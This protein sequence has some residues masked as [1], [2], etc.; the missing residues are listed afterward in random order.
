MTQTGI[1]GWVQKDGKIVDGKLD[2]SRLGVKQQ[3]QFLRSQQLKIITHIN[4]IKL[5]AENRFKSMP[6]GSTMTPLQ[7][8]LALKLHALKSSCM[9]LQGFNDN[10]CSL[11]LSYEK[12]GC[13]AE[14]LAELQSEIE[15]RVMDL[16]H[17]ANEASEISLLEKAIEI[18]SVLR[19]NAHSQSE[20]PEPTPAFNFSHHIYALKAQEIL[21]RSY[22]D[23]VSEI[24]KTWPDELIVP[25]YYKLIWQAKMDTFE[26]RMKTFIHNA[27]EQIT[28]FR[29]IQKSGV[30]PSELMEIGGKVR[31]M[32]LTNYTQALNL[33]VSLVH[34]TR[35]IAVASRLAQVS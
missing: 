24:A 27:K 15:R 3:T 18:D 12:Y 14:E 1:S 20:N 30:N 33:G 13:T 32:V 34:C 7:K 26:G 31:R 28:F 2:V 5:D 23:L 10:L 16:S 25:S 9:T 8:G 19:S 29:Q 21:V 22:G 6:P 17:I 11:M 35:D 4:D